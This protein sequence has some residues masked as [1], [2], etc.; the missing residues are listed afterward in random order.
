MTLLC[1]IMSH[2]DTEFT[3]I[4]WGCRIN[5]MCV[6]ART[7]SE[8]ERCFAA[9]CGLVQYDELKAP[10]LQ[11]RQICGRGHGK[12]GTNCCLEMNYTHTLVSAQQG[13]YA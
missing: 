10:E 6:S 3:D 4:K 13:S 2:A 5:A 8:A 9:P 7:Q 1:V 12:D 11:Q